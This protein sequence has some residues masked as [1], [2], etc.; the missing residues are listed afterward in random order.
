LSGGRKRGLFHWLG[1]R[2]ETVCLA[3]GYATAASIHES[4][5]YRVFVCFDCGNLTAVAEAVRGL[6]PDA[7]MVICADNDL[8]DRTGRQ[9]GQ[10]KAAEAAGLVGGCVALPP[11]AG[12]DFN[13]FAAI[14]REKTNGR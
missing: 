9:A 1:K 5:G 10:E 3:E 8:P 12:A 13:D 7:R 6:L 11:V 4:T 2:T 14:L